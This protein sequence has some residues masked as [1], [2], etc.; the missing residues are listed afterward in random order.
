MRP[1]CIFSAKSCRGIFIPRIS[2]PGMVAQER[3]HAASIQPL[4]SI[5]SSF[6]PLGCLL[7]NCLPRTRTSCSNDGHG[8]YFAEAPCFPSTLKLASLPLASGA[9]LR[10]ALRGPAAPTSLPRSNSYTV[11]FKVS[12]MEWQHKNEVSIHRTTQH[13]SIGWGG[14]GGGRNR[15]RKHRKSW[16]IIMHAYFSELDT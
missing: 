7:L 10:L 3:S 5:A 15:E 9:S 14:G 13:F 12:V 11:R 1:P 2:P 8:S 6:K 4:N 16:A